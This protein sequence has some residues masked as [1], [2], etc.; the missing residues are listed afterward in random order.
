M[1]CSFHACALHYLYELRSFPNN[2]RD[3]TL[4]D[5]VFV[6]LCGRSRPTLKDDE[7]AQRITKRVIQV[8]TQE[9]ELLLSGD[10]TPLLENCPDATRCSSYHP[11]SKAARKKGSPVLKLQLLKRFACK[12]G[13]YV[14]T[15]NEMNLVDL[16]LVSTNSRLAGRLASE[17][18]MRYLCKCSGICQ[19][20]QRKAASLPDGE[21]FVLNMCMDAARISKQQA[22]PQ[23]DM[24]TLNMTSA[25]FNVP[26]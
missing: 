5:L 8:F 9:A 23:G 22:R 21:P 11:M 19:A 10:L 4:G 20:L 16:G 1:T 26:R 24:S 3:I 15:K 25:F 12:A 7:D 2:A 13:G 6:L 17:F 14:T 18:V